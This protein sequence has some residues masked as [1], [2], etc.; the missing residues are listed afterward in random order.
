MG[1]KLIL[2]A[3]TATSPFIGPDGNPVT[4]VSGFAKT[5]D[6]V[7]IMN[8]DVWVFIHLCSKKRPLTS[9]LGPLESDCRP[10]LSSK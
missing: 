4:D 6:Y 1:S 10:K 9:H 3:A 5:L 8:Y 2:S 7:A